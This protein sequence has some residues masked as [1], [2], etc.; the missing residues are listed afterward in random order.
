MPERRE[1]SQL[2]NQMSFTSLPRP[3]L[4]EQRRMQGKGSSPNATHKR[5]KTFKNIKNNNT[6]LWN[7][8]QD[9]SGQT[10]FKDVLSVHTCSASIP[11]LFVFVRS[12]CVWICGLDSDFEWLRAH[13]QR[14][15]TFGSALVWLR[16]RS[17]CMVQL[18]AGEG[19]AA[20]YKSTCHISLSDLGL[21]LGFV[22]LQSKSS[23]I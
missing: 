21:F 13:L 18:L 6:T 12:G 3:R 19:W 23:R 7:R 2:P 8:H 22:N 5:A 9:S 16:R 1:G 11:Y 14:Q 20:S 10:Y 4:E 17:L 15:H